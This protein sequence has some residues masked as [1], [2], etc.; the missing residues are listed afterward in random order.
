MARRT[1]VGPVHAIATR[2]DGVEKVVKRG[3]VVDVSEETAALL[4]KCPENWAPPK[5]PA[6]SAPL[7][8]KDGD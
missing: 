3:E 6:P 8:T 4:D 5:A 7:T 1:Y 2:L